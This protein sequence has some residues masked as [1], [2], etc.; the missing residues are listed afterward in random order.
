M[1]DDTVDDVRSEEERRGR[2]PIDIAEKRRNLII[3]KKFLEA[4]KSNNEEQFREMIIHDLSQ[5]PGSQAYIQSVQA[6]KDYHGEK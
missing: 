4:I 2:R 6:W 1:V 3:R 5:T